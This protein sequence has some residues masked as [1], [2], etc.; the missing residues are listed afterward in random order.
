MPKRSGENS[1]NSYRLFE[2]K[3]FAKKLDKLDPPDKTFIM[4]KLKTYIYPQLRQQ[5][6]FG[7]NIKKLKDHTPEVWR[8]RIGNYR[9]FYTIDPDDQI[10]FM[11]TLDHRKDAYR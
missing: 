10:I 5:P 3:E 7:K 9:V 4:N 6:F 8:Y 2:T 11:L 1:L